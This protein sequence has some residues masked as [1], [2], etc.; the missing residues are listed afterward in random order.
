M[1]TDLEN[2]EKMPE[3]EVSLRLALFLIRNKLVSSDV[4]VAQEY[5]LKNKV[6]SFS[7]I[8]AWNVGKL[9]VRA[10]GKKDYKILLSKLNSQKPAF[11]RVF[12]VLL[13]G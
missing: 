1:D 6:K 3:A 11:W 5:H 13:L 9:G 12:F 10:K 7:G 8:P 4:S 2:P